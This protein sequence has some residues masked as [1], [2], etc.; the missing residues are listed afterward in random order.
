MIFCCVKVRVVI[1]IML[2]LLML[3]FVIVRC[4]SYVDGDSVRL[5]LWVVTLV[6]YWLLIME[7]G[8]NW[9]FVLV[10]K[11]VVIL[12]LV[13]LVSICVGIVVLV[14]DVD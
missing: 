14:L 11:L 6:N 9:L 10:S 5:V 13:V 4:V 8:L 3:F 1:V 7:N 2:L 12:C